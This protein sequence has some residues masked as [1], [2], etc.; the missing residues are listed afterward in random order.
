MTKKIALEDSDD[1]ARFIET[2]PL[3]GRARGDMLP[4]CGARAQAVTT[5]NCRTALPRHHAGDQQRF[6]L[7]KWL[8]SGCADSGYSGA[9]QARRGPCNI[10]GR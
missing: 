7:A 9:D 4:Q 5:A 8:R 2:A 10:R 1:A 3:S 6:R